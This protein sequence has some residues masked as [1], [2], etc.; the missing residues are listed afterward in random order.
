MYK[1]YNIDQLVL[2]LDVEVFIPKNHLCRIVH[3]AVEMM[4]DSILL[5]L[6]P[7]GGR[8]PYHPK[9]ML[10]VLLFAYC[11]GIYSSRKIADELKQNIYF[12][13]FLQNTHIKS[14]PK[15]KRGM[16]LKSHIIMNF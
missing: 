7:G 10:K 6:H 13:F 3:Q 8:P 15:T 14:N 2:P 5:S 11:K 16:S 4:D 12:M 1:E 9:M